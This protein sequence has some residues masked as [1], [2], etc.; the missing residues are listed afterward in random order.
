MIRD[1]ST[2]YLLR[3]R[4]LST[5]EVIEVIEVDHTRILPRIQRFR[6][7]VIQESLDLQSKIST[8]GLQP[9]IMQR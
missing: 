7:E 4:Q 2:R 3:S 1:S 5:P 8:S 6:V 9:P